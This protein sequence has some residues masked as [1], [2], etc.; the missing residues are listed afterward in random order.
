MR[1]VE[2]FYPSNTV[3]TLLWPLR[4]LPR[5]AIWKSGRLGSP[6]A[7][8][9]AGDLMAHSQRDPVQWQGGRKWRIKPDAKQ[10]C[11]ARRIPVQAAGA[12]EREAET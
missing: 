8:A 5:L 1:K 6:I 4:A 3:F 11:L 7:P 2:Y 9:L 12:W 10:A